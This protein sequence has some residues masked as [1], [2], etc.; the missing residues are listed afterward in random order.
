MEQCPHSKIYQLVRSAQ[1]VAHKKRQEFLSSLV[2]SMIRSRSVVFHELAYEIEGDAKLSSKERRIQNFFQCVEFDY[3]AL[4]KLLLSMIGHRKLVL[5]MDRTEWDFGKTQINILCIGV[6]I[7]KML[8]PLYF[9]N[10]DNNSGNSNSEDRRAL[11]E[12]LI[13]VIGKQRIECLVMDREFIGHS[14]LSWLKKEQIPFCVRVPKH[15]QLTTIEGDRLKVE[16]WLGDQKIKFASN[17]YVDQTLVNV[18]ASYGADGKLLYLIG[19]DKA[20]NLRKWYQKRWAIEVFFQAT[21]GRGFNM[22]QS[23]L[24][25]FNKYRKLFA[26][27]ALSYTLAWATGIESGRAEPVKPKK[28]GYPQYSVFRRGLNIIRM[29]FKAKTTLKYVYI[30]LNKA[31]VRLNI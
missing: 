23:R 26:I 21:K 9:E 2:L 18:S 15:H 12:E 27:V 14:W 8:V 25:D 13:E 7:G 17:A 24:R 6:S 22:E 10:L 11:L 28:H 19:T 3:K 30:A 1:V 29:Y 4:C 31:R 16:Q 5:S 20:L